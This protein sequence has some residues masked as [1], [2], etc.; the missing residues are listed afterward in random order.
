MQRDRRPAHPR[1]VQRSQQLG[2]EVQPGGRRRYRPKPRGEDGLVIR[3]IAGIGCVASNVRRQ[4]RRSVGVQ[5]FRHGLARAAEVEQQRA[6]RVLARDLRLQAGSE[7]H[8]VTRPQAAGGRARARQRPGANSSI[9]VASTD[10]PPRRPNS[11][12]GMTRVVQDQQITFRSSLGSSRT[13]RSSSCPS[14][15]SRVRVA[16]AR[17]MLRDCFGRQSKI[18]PLDP[19]RAPSLLEAPDWLKA[20][21]D[22]GSQP[23]TRSGRRS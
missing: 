1:R 21:L 4:R 15:H 18:E 20:R 12:V 2:R 16:R 8:A 17:R 5:V 22:E 23:P 14:M 9:S 13:L 10:T 11:R 6:F 3:P 19:H 7:L